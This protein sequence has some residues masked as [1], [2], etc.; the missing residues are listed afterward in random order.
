MRKTVIR[1]IRLAFAVFL[2]SVVPDTNAARAQQQDGIP[3]LSGRWESVG[4][5]G[6]FDPA[7]PYGPPPFNAEGRA[8]KL[9]FDD[10]TENPVYDC[11]GPGVPSVLIVPYMLEIEQRTDELVLHHEYFDTVRIVGL[12]RDTHPDGLDRT[13]YGN[14]IGYYEGNTL[15]VDTRGFAFDRIGMDMSGGPSSDQKKGHRA[16]YQER[17]RSNPACGV[18]RGRPGLPRRTLRAGEGIPLCS[19]PGALRVRMRTGVCG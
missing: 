1:M 3:D 11:I 4:W 2:V 6:G 19:G 5:F 8:L 14:S 18:H 9:S 13:I 7:P 17:R 12:N 10:E 15:V 16:I